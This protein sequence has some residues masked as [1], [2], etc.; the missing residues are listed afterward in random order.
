MQRSLPGSSRRCSPGRPRRRR[1]ARVTPRSRAMSSPSR[2]TPPSRPSTPG[3]TG[4][5][6]RRSSWRRSPPTNRRFAR[7]AR[8]VGRAATAEARG[9]SCRCTSARGRRSRDGRARMSQRT[10][11]CASAPGS[12]S[13]A[14]RSA[15]APGLRRTRSSAPTHRVSVA[16]VPSRGRWSHGFLRTPQHHP[17]MSDAHLVYVEKTADEVQTKREGVKGSVTRND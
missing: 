16:K 7:T 15:C 6:R 2:S 8:T 17:L 1:T 11:S 5:P 12:T 9:A 10:A 3:T 14:S 13:H 4:A